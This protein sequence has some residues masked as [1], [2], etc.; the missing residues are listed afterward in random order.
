MYLV[1]LAAPTTSFVCAIIDI[2]PRV[3]V[4]SRSAI[5]RSAV[6]QVLIHA[7]RNP[8]SLYSNDRTLSLRD[9]LHHLDGDA[10]QRWTVNGQELVSNGQNTPFHGV[11]MTG[12]VSHTLLG[13]RLVYGKAA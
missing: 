9:E 7:T 2:G 13:G 6:L 5:A 4:D 3:Q 12:R 11:E 8:K 10:E 1:P